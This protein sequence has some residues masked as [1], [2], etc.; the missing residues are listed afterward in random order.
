MAYAHTSEE[1]NLLFHR[2]I[3]KKSKGKPLTPELSQFVMLPAVMLF[4]PGAEFMTVNCIY[5]YCGH[6]QRDL[7]VGLRRAGT[8]H[9]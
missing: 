5:P 1:Q 8:L 2:P 4:K 3:K 7:T 6:Q 9:I